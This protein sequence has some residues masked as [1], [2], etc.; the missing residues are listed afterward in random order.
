MKP[1]DDEIRLYIGNPHTFFVVK[2]AGVQQ[3][4]LLHSMIKSQHGEA[5]IMSP[6]LSSIDPPTFNLVA[7]YLNYGEYIPNLIDQGT[8]RARL[9]NVAP[10]NQ[11]TDVLANCGILFGMGRDLDLVGLQE[12]VVRKFLA[13]APHA[14]DYDVL[15][16][17][18]MFYF[19]GRP[20][21]E[22]LHA[23]L[24]TWLA[25]G[26]F[27]IWKVEAQALREF[28]IEHREILRDVTRVVLKKTV[29]EIGDGGEEE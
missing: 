17:A 15:A 5:Y 16:L 12:L 3:S 4:D 9:E 2:K 10:G 26:L 19:H 1:S 8:D 24:I 18:R 22:G 29:A 20:D 14:E 23:W 11:M 13:L 28:L 25:E 21:V 6:L 7:E 27:D